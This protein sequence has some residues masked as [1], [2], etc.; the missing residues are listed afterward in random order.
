MQ[1]IQ[2][3]PISS[4]TEMLEKLKQKFSDELF[5]LVDHYI[6]EFKNKKFGN[7]TLKTI[8]Q[9]M[10]EIQNNNSTTEQLTAVEKKIIYE[11]LKGNSKKVFGEKN[12][13]VFQT[14]TK[15]ISFPV[16]TVSSSSTSSTERREEVSKRKISEISSS[17]CPEP[18]KLKVIS[19]ASTSTSTV[20]AV[21]EECIMVIENEQETSISPPSMNEPEEKHKIQR[22]EEKEIFD[23]LLKPDLLLNRMLEIRFLEEQKTFFDLISQRTLNLN[24]VWLKKLLKKHYLSQV[25][26]S[27][28]I[29]IVKQKKENYSISRELNHVITDLVYE[30]RSENLEIR[31]LNSFKELFQHWKQG[32]VGNLKEL[33]DLMLK[34]QEFLKIE[35]SKIK[36]SIKNGEIKK[37]LEIVQV[38]FQMISEDAGN[39]FQIYL[40]AKNFE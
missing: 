3:S 29:E 15:M 30:K 38:Y 31:I 2:N 7:Q 17:T 5:I 11:S 18:K 13:E 26:E 9:R 10:K 39:I 28:F 8:L 6:E 37:N 40:K 12:P 4:L 16:E 14:K 1:Q 36:E 34:N 19:I 32:N 23:F 24:V 33:N 22:V 20:S 35:V 25:T 27:E 21:E